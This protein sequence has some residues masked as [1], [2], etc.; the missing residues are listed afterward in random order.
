MKGWGFIFLLLMRVAVSAEPLMGRQPSQ[1]LPEG[2]LIFIS[3][4]MPDA[5]L[6]AL[7]AQAQA[8]H[9]PLVV[10]G[11][12]NNS[13]QETLQRLKTLDEHP[14]GL[15]VNPIWFRQLGI[16]QVPAFVAAS[17]GTAFCPPH[18]TCFPPQFDVVFGNVSLKTALNWLSEHGSGEPAQIAKDT[19]SQLE[20][21]HG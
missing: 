5:S 20:N 16:T 13:S 19:L 17:S 18:T 6:K 2:V 1:P 10:R 4:G 21:T 14:P 12:L 3:L 8:A 15:L 11:F 9:V 7:F